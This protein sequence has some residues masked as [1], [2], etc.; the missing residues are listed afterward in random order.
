MGFRK[1]TVQLS[2]VILVFAV[3]SDC[4][5]LTVE[6]QPD[7][8]PMPYFTSPSN[9]EFMSTVDPNFVKVFESN[10][11]L[12]VVDLSDEDNITHAL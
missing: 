5:V 12:R 9:D 7:L 6:A 10:V 2:L 1:A 11:E 3:F 8:P 4:F